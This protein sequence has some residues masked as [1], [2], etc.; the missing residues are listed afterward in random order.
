M[1]EIEPDDA[2]CRALWSAVVYQAIHDMDTFNERRAAINWLYSD[3]SDVG[4]MRWICDMLDF[5][6]HK[7][8]NLCMT[9]EGR[10]KI[11][12]KETVTLRSKSKAQ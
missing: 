9:R 8:M 6:Y 4:S 5:D 2:G 12:K 11:L 7:L 1:T 10:S 3:R